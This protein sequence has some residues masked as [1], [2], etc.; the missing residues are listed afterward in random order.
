LVLFLDRDRLYSY[1]QVPNAQATYSENS[2]TK[3]HRAIAISR[4]DEMLACKK[5]ARNRASRPVSFIPFNLAFK[6][7]PEIGKKMQSLDTLESVT[8]PFIVQLIWC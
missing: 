8:I 5:Q 4:T 2:G 7:I 3:Y 1:I 6:W